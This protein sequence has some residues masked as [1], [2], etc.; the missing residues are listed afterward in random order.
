MKIQKVYFLKS[1]TNGK[2]GEGVETGANFI[3]GSGFSMVNL[4]LN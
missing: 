1:N 3:L 2:S 4:N